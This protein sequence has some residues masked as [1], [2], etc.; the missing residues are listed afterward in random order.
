MQK[1]NAVYSY[2]K[3]CYNDI[4]TLINKTADTR[5][6]NILLLNNTVS[7]TC[8]ILVTVLQLINSSNVLI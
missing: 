4:D 6:K 5:I 2:H 8:T 7:N 3:S 1:A